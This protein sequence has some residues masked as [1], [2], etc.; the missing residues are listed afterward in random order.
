M[1]LFT[2]PALK[3]VDAQDI[4][5]RYYSGVTGFGIAR[6]DEEHVIKHGGA[7]TYGEMT[8]E[9]TQKLLDYL[10]PQKTDVFV[11]AGSGVGKLVSQVFFTTDVSKC[12]GIELSKERH[13]KAVQVKK[14]LEKDSLVPQGRLLE[15]HNTDI[16]TAD[17][18]D[19][20]IFFMCSTCFSP[21]LMQ[22]ITAK[23][24]G[25]K[26]GLRVVTLKHLPDNEEC[27]VLRNTLQLPMTWSASTPVYIYEL[28]EKK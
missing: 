26:P 15:F 14:N 8:I 21:E 6:D 25:L 18:N 7:P 19:V 24:A 28:V 27:F 13:A 17:L 4:L 12:V 22:K 23:L 16:L 2:V 1:G 3:K 9:G 11:D 10:K 20:T 5:Q